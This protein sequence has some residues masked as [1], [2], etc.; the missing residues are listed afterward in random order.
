MSEQ[1]TPVSETPADRPADWPAVL[2]VAPI[3]RAAGRVAL[4]GSKS[5]S[6]RLLLLAALAE[7]TTELVGLLEADDT[8]VMLQ[9]LQAL[10]VTIE[11]RGAAVVIHGAAGRWP[12]PR[13]DLALGNAGTA[14][15]SLAAAL[16]FAGG[17]YTLDGV[18]RMRERPIG[19]L[20]DALN[21]LGARVS[22]LRRWRSHR[23]NS[24]EPTRCRSRAMYRAS[25]SAAC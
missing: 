15:R 5:I 3:A 6:N 1:P 9:A 17:H 4:P 11:R 23:R 7:G 19:D 13:A 16:A 12:N 24:S 21:A 18:A 2:T 10:G 20:V 25:S 22:Y 14:M 8:R